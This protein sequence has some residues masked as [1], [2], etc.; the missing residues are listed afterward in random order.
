[1]ISVRG[2]SKTYHSDGKSH[3]AICDISFE[4]ASGQ[5][6]TLLGASG[7]GKS[8]TL[9]CVAGLEQPDA[10][11]VWIGDRLVYS[12]AKRV[13]MGAAKRGIG[14]VFQSYAIW[15]HMSVFENVAYPLK[16]QQVRAPER[17]KRVYQA[18]D[19]VDLVDLAERPAPSLSGGQQQRVALARAII[20][21]PQVLLL[22]EPLSNLDARL[23]RGLRGYLRSL[24]K[25]LGLTVLYV[26]HDQAEAMAMS[27]VVVLLNEGRVMEA[28]SP[29][30]IYQRPTTE[31]GARF[32]GDANIFD[33][34]V[35]RAEAGRLVHK[36]DFGEVAVSVDTEHATSKSTYAYGGEAS[37]MVRPEDI[38]VHRKGRDSQ[39]PEV[40]VFRGVVRTALFLGAD[41][42]L[43]V[44]IGEGR[45]L[46]VRNP[47]RVVTCPGDDVDIVFAPE[48]VARLL[49]A[50]EVNPA[51]QEATIV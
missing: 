27:D 31:F 45:V 47:G 10:G 41:Q 8:T 30:D 26:T 17:K 25:R 2:L 18:L 3:E 22:D 35:D 23:R 9:R 13:N 38:T 11:E 48:S 49:G 20:A 32:V 6:M 33:G 7:C 16:R 34:I 39:A 43:E 5:F 15:P 4:T 40:N 37:L 14:M 50:S 46:H 42:E 29:Q 28:G 36:T 19:M 12:A 1:M 24:Q 44:E 51:G 21:E